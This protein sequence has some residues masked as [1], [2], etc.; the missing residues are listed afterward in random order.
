M[1]HGKMINL[2]AFTSRHEL[3]GTKFNGP[4]VCPTEK[5][6][7]LAAFRNWEPE[8]QAL[9]DVSII[10]SALIFFYGLG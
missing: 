5:Q 7:F 8:V 6:E 4:W 1:A 3:E 9:L 10:P 2:V